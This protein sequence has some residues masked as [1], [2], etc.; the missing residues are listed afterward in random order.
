MTSQQRFGA[1]LVTKRRHTYYV[2]EQW[3]INW[4]VW[5]YQS[6]HIF[7][8]IHKLTMREKNYEMY[9][10]TKK[11]YCSKVLQRP[12]CSTLAKPNMGLIKQ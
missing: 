2:W 9:D 8:A 5:W 3:T 11:V 1:G 12:K 10:G 6:H 4:N 7:E